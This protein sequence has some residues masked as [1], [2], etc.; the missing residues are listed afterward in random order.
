MKSQLSFNVF[1]LAGTIMLATSL[2]LLFLY[3]TSGGAY[4]F[5]DLN[6]VAYSLIPIPQLSILEWILYISMISTVVFYYRAFKHARK[7][8]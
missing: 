3:Y 5:L 4:N 7:G 6:Q 1:F 2:I 8:K